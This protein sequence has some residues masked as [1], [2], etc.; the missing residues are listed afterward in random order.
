MAHFISY[1][2]TGNLAQNPVPGATTTLTLDTIQTG[3]DATC[4]GWVIT[5]QAGTLLIDQSFDNI[6]WDYT[7]SVSVA[8]ASGVTST[9]GYVSTGAGGNVAILVVAEGSTNGVPVIAPFLRARYTTGAT[10]PTV[11]RIF[12]RCFGNRTS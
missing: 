4:C 8:A 1:D 2:T 10:P 5:D 7:T 12:I 6:N 3:I 11:L 9:P